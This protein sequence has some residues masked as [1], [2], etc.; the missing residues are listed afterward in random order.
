MC[1]L[2]NNF[3]LLAFVGLFFFVITIW[4]TQLF[5]VYNSFTASEET[6]KIIFFFLI[7]KNNLFS[8]QNRRRRRL[9]FFCSRIIVS[10]SNDTALTTEPII[11]HVSVFYIKTTNRVI[12]FN[13]KARCFICFRAETQN[14]KK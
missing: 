5:T 6:P 1:H 2:I 12:F 4:H 10:S 7:Q 8:L 14:T 11:I 13:I 3:V 9:A